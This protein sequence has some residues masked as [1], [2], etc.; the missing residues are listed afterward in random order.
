LLPGIEHVEVARSEIKSKILHTQQT[1][2]F[3]DEDIL[4]RIREIEKKHRR[5]QRKVNEIRTIG[6]KSASLR[7]E[8][9]CMPE[10]RIINNL[11]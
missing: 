1:V 3:K 8:S 9:T 4:S 10:L 5:F 11:F 2:S 6:G 7:K